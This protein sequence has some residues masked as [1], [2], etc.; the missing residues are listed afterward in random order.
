[1]AYD[2]SQFR[3]TY[4]E[5]SATTT[6]HVFA[7][8]TL[9]QERIS[10]AVWGEHYNSAVGLMTAVLLA[11]SPF[12]FRARPN[13]QAQPSASTYQEQLDRLRQAV[14]RRILVLY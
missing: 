7:K 5:F 2:I 12:A 1:M 6:A 3:T 9:A 10:E 4:P 14:P 8:L 13:P 11:S